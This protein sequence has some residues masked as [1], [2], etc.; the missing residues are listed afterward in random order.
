[1]TTASSEEK[2]GD[3]G[4][5]R[6]WLLRPPFPEH[7]TAVDLR[8]ASMV[9]GLLVVASL[10]LLVVW[11]LAL[12]GRAG[13]DGR[14]LGVFVTINVSLLTL[15]LALTL[16]LLRR[17]GRFRTVTQ[18]VCLVLEAAAIV[19]A[20]H[21]TGGVAG[22]WVAAS[23]MF[24]LC[25]R[26]FFDFDTAL[27]G[28]VALTCLHS[29]DLV[30]TEIGI[31]DAAGIFGSDAG[32]VLSGSLY[33][34]VAFPAILTMYGFTFVIG[35]GIVLRLRGRE[36]A[37][38]AARE[39][40]LHVANQAKIGRLSGTVLAG[41]Y[42]IGEV[43]GRGGMG[44]VYAA[45]VLA[46]AQRVAIKVLHPHL[47]QDPEM[48][49]RFR[50]EVES[51]QRLPESYVARVIEF[52]TSAEGQFLVMELLEGQDLSAALREAGRLS[53]LD[54]VALCGAIADILDAAHDAGI[55]HRD[56]KPS[57]IFLV[58]AIGTSG[59]VR[60]LDFGVAHLAGARGTTVTGTAALLG[61]PGYLAPEQALAQRVGPAVDVFALG[62]IAY[63]AITGEAAF[64][65]RSI[66]AALYEAVHWHPPP[67]C[68][69]VPGL[70]GDVD[71]ALA[72]ALAKGPELRFS[73][74]SE[75]ARALAAAAR[76]EL[77]DDLRRRG[78]TARPQALPD[79]TMTAVA[80]DP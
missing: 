62:A 24:I 5:F 39:N 32:C 19:N 17:P 14:A 46:G 23:I 21:F 26:V 45:R 41:T 59:A 35:N 37:L 15:V 3:L 80:D 50:R 65:A 57:N 56:L 29:A 48:L 79:Q 73:R 42:E 10:P 78:R 8:T 75:F 18:R 13:V 38:R 43:I 25:Y 12:R 76:G 77:A 70:P 61:S 49:A 58:H 69:R 2:T 71:L 7:L 6:R 64:P 68:S 72:L 40:L 67:P 9:R 30:L 63:R 33:R 22:P 1:M 51:A 66:S 54:T 52:G 60:L 55:V 36:A 34:R 4:F 31:L 11:F 44:E 27:F 74:A 20:L 53:I 16:A 47:A 28:F